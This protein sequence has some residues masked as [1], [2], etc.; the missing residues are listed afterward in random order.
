[1]PAGR[2]P[3]CTGQVVVYIHVISEF[4]DMVA[5]H[6]VVKLQKAGAHLPQKRIL[7]NKITIF[8]HGPLPM[9]PSGTSE[10]GELLLLW[11]CDPEKEERGLGQITEL[12]KYYDQKSSLFL[13]DIITDRPLVCFRART[14]S[15][16]GGLTSGGDG[17]FICSSILIVPLE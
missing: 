11:L 13:F 10:A 17:P 16:M 15:R 12:R 3:Q 5:F 8:R 1:M 6:S 14:D 9:T 2:L 4:C 7:D